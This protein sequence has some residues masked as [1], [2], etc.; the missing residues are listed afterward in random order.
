[1][2]SNDYTF[3]NIQDYIGKAGTALLLIFGL[4]LFLVFKIRI[5]PDKIKEAFERPSKELKDEAIQDQLARIAYLDSIDFLLGLLN[6]KFTK[7][8]NCV[9]YC[10]EAAPLII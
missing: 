1:M 8:P 3:E 7:P 6:L 9:P 2:S 10:K 4:V 5:S